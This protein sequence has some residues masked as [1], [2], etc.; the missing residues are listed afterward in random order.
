M[1]MN[2]NALTDALP[3][4]DTRLIPSLAGTAL[5][6][7]YHLTEVTR[8][9]LASIDCGGVQSKRQEVRIQLMEG[10]G[11]PLTAARVRRIF[12]QA[13]EALGDIG[14]LDVVV[15][16]APAG[17]AAALW[18]P[19]GVVA[20]EEG[21]RLELAPIAPACRPATRTGGCCGPRQSAA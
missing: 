5:P 12:G 14:T 11:A 18:R 19:I 2:F 3:E 13:V 7:G 15:E 4:A 9:D 17:R 8:A 16:A 21:L 10:T 20:A 1:S 6:P